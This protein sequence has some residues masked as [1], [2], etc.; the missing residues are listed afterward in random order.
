MGV[1]FDKRPEKRRSGMEAF[2]SRVA[3]KKTAKSKEEIVY[4]SVEAFREFRPTH[5]NGKPANQKRRY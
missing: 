2:F 1:R 4:L 3:Y 5:K